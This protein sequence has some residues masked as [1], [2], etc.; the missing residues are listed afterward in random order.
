MYFD[1]KPASGSAHAG[2]DG[3]TPISRDPFPSYRVSG[4]PT[5]TIAQENLM[6]EVLGPDN[7]SGQ[8]WDS[9]EAVFGPRNEQGN[10]A[11]LY[12]PKSGDLNKTVAEQYRKYDIG[13]LLR[14][15][16]ERYLPLFHN[17][18]RI[19]VGDQ[20][21]FYLNEAVALL[22]AQVDELNSKGGQTP[23]WGSITIVPGLDHGSIMM[24]PPVQAIPE[25]MV[26][27]LTSAGHLPAPK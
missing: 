18:V 3:T 8:Q 7:T 13:D 26:E 22:K 23:G 21:S 12:D 2:A 24:S 5:M 27:R 4:K 9:W 20:D 25:Q 6:E 1:D 19:V 10:P 11:A 14:T 16:P 17:N 15:H